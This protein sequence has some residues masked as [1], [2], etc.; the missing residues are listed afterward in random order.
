MFAQEAYMRSARTS[1]AFLHLVFLTFLYGG[2]TGA[3]AAAQAIF[4]A[5]TGTVTDS[6]GAV[7]PGATVNVTNIDT[8][9]TKTLTT[10]A[11]GVYNATNLIP[12]PYKV[13]ASLSGF[14]TAVISPVTLEV[15]AN[16]KI[17]VTL[18]LGPASETVDVAAVAPLLQTER[19][20]LG[21]TVTQQQIEQLPTAR[22]LFNLIPLAAGVSQQQTCDGCGNNGN[23]RINGD[24][25]RNQ[26]YILDG[27]T[28]TAPVFGGQ[29]FNPSVDSIQEFR[30]ETNSMSAEYGK[31]GGGVL[32]AV[33]KS[34]TNAFRGSGYLYK[35]NEHLNSRNYF[36]D[37]SKPKN[38]FD[39]NEFG[40]TVGGPLMRNK[41]FFFSDYQGLRI[42]ASSPVTGVVV[43]NAAFRSGDLAALCTAGFDAAGVCA[44]AAQQL[45]FPGTTTLLP[46]NR[47]P[48]N[49]ISAISRKFLD[50]WPQSPTPGA[51]PGTSELSFTLPSQNAINRVNSRIDYQL[52]AKDQVFGVFHRQWGRSISYV[53][54]LIAGPESEQIGRSGDYAVTLGW[55][56]TFAANLLNNF[57]L[58]QMHRI[59][60]RTNAGQGF[61]SPSDFGLQGIPNCLASVPDTAGG[62]KCGTPG[63][64]V[65]GYQGF[66]TGGVLY[67]PA[68]TLT[69]SD[70][71]TTLRG[72]HS[73][74]IGGEARRYA[75]D[76]YQPNGLAS[77]FG[78]TGSRTGNAF[79]D[80]LFG[81][82]NNGFV[83]V[84]NAMVS[85]RAWSY[86]AFVQD[87]FKASSK[88]TINAGVRWQY[89]Q[90][91]RELHDGLAFFNPF[92]AEW[93]QF[94]VNA[95]ATSF[96][97]SM[98]Q[99]AP[100]VGVAWNTTATIVVRAGYGLSYPSAVGHGR[101]GD[102]Q[103]GPNMLAR[104]N[105]PAGTN[106]SALP[107]VTTPD[108]AAIRAPI[109]VTGNVSFSSWAPRE[110]TWPHYHLWNATVE[111]QL[112]H[113]SAVQLSYVGSRGRNLPINYAYNICQQTP[114]STAQFG[115]AAT[116]SPYCPEAAARVLAAGGSLY[117]LVVNPGYWGLSSSDYDALQ[118]KFERRFSR[119][120][121]LLAN[122]TWSRL[123][124]DSSSD[125]GG[126]WSLD[127]LG[128][129]FYNRK[130]E[131]SVSAGDI[132]RRLTVAGIVELPF[133]PGK[134]WATDGAAGQILGGWRATGVYTVSSGS[135]FGIT[136]NSYGY[137]NASHTLTNRPM[138]VRDPLPAGF[139]QTIG[140]WFDRN[141]F[142]FSGTCPAPGLPAPTGGG[143]PKKAFGDAPR[144]FSDVRN[145][146]VSKLDFSLQKDVRLPGGDA[147][148]FQFRADFFNLLNRSQ[149][150]EPISDPLN[151]S[152]GR[153]TSTSIPNRVVQLGLHLFF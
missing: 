40:G 66:T 140:A 51:S 50:I 131:R 22:N 121:S 44:N 82:T 48:T 11:A 141:A 104:T 6:S 88:L 91:F 94:G 128:Q 118:A 125:W 36:E 64:S 57:R 81:A 72:R 137:C 143:D 42:D 84:Q 26:D 68:N 19:T 115:Y 43:P 23:L 96:D 80:F 15:N 146:G 139:N 126:F 24:R 135:P 62:T 101:A 13:E 12:G 20:S 93:E 109:P 1:A 75:I 45:H 150:A 90:S 123:M 92:T 21:Q 73:L 132:P 34:G 5:I 110:Q 29:A 46:F 53:G 130:A 83:Q 124:D 117:D 145:P 85:T 76:N 102:G 52:S 138:L 97:P 111:K 153:I 79:A 60:H 98:K 31:A 87:D 86:S 7:L 78:F 35:R 37:R 120:V 47:I 38:P 2:M 116:T 134:R 16:Q 18:A 3:P 10:N 136:D 119:G 70:I 149:F 71:V 148:R 105:F 144:Y 113:S 65:S 25:P 14:K 49:Q 103:P 107:H 129:D 63:V 58:G 100:R 127:V 9:V 112:D 95:P 114:E 30:I 41:L 4:A 74:K 56:R 59:G 17:D 151:G 32:I 152:F 33:T 8:N 39:Q 54:N 99:F 106:W 27:A 61:T 142:D 69:I 122:F 55:S 28:M 147:R 108:A 133:G 67:E 89:D 77:S